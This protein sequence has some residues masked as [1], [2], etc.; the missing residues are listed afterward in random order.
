MLSFNNFG[1]GFLFC[2]WTAV[3][4]SGCA[5]HKETALS[6]TGSAS[7]SPQALSTTPTNSTGTTTGTVYSIVA[8]DANSRVWART[9]YEL[10]PSGESVPHVQRYEETATGLNFKNPDTG[11]WEASSE[12]IEQVP[13]GATAQHGQHKV[14]FADDLATLGAIDMET[15]DGQKVQSHLLGLSY[16]DT[17]S[18]QSVMIAEVTNCIGQL[19][20]SNQVWYEGAFSGLKAS[21]RYTYTREG[22]EQDVILEERPQAPEAYGLNSSSTVLQALTEFVSYPTPVL[23]TNSNL[24]QAGLQIPDE[25]LSFGA[26]RIG[27]G[28]AFLMGSDSNGVSVSKEWLTLNGRQ[29]LVEEVPIG[30][31]ATQLQ[32]LPLTQSSSLSP[33]SNSVLN[34][35]SEKRLLPAQPLATIG[36]N[37]M[38]FASQSAMPTGM[39]LDYISLNTSQTNYVFQTDTT[40][41]FSGNVNLFGTNTIFEGATVLKYASGVS[42]TVNTPVTWSAGPYRPVVMVAK[43]DNTVGETVS[44]STGAPGSAF[45]ATKAL[46]F[47]GASA[48]TNLII[49][50]LRILNANAG[51]VLNGQSGHVLNDIQLLKCGNGIAATNTDF[52]LHNALFGNVLTN[53]TGSNVTANVEH[54]TSSTATWL[55][56]NIGANLFLT[57]CLLAAVTNLGNCSTQNVAVLST[58]NNVFQTVGGGSYYLAVDSPYRNA[59]TTNISSGMLTDLMQKTTFPPVV[60]QDTN[61]NVVTTFNPVVQRDSD[62]PDLGYHYDPLDYAFSGVVANTN[63]TFAAGTAVGWYIAGSD[64]SALH[65]ANKQIATFSGTFANPDYFVR[66]STAQEGGNGNWTKSW[67]IMGVIGTADQNLQDVTLSPELRMTFSACS[68]LSSGEQSFRDYSGYLIVRANNCRITGG[69]QGGYIISYY[70]TN[71]LIDGGQIGTVAGWTGNE[72]YLRNCTLHEELLYISRYHTPPMPV[73][74]RDCSFDPANLYTNGDAFITNTNYSDFD[75]NAYTNAAAIFPVG[76]SH[77]QKSVTFNWQAGPLGIF[78]LPTGSVLIDGGD[79]T[80]DAVGLYHFTTQA[81]QYSQEGTSTVDIGYH[82][83]AVDFYNNPVDSNSDGI[84]DYIEDANGNGI[85]DSGETDWQHLDAG[86]NIL[87]TRPRNGSTLP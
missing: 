18:G 34:V 46:Y 65:L 22:F 62:I 58:T 44:G 61:I 64:G 10:L 31:I 24:P 67:G 82:Y 37:Q 81:S 41:F 74:I 30:S 28:R 1:R 38:K 76:C 36:T 17:A 20:G 29:F 35:V 53:F 49:Q 56:Q 60:Y 5:S 68:A 2:T 26:M 80:A 8:Q 25:T 14:I 55:N 3:L 59:G 39:V 57:N 19:V 52:G 45:Y 7:G 84:P 54:L 48:L 23:S 33:A 11:Q 13:G 9:N 42:L 85:V 83:L 21:V 63:I 69:N 78:Y 72:M 66:C 51:I 71:C 77:D 87:I 75:Y 32:T 86:L 47:N 40:Y 27:R 6:P 16:L 50:N 12:Q 79:V 70:L 73:S 4:L 15:P 43:D